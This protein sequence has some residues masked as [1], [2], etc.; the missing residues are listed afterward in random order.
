[1]K[2]LANVL[3]GA[4]LIL[5]GLHQLGGVS[6]P[7]SSIILAVLAAVTG[8]VFFFADSSEKISKQLGSILLGVYLVMI[9]AMSLFHISFPGSYVILAAIAVAA[10]VV[11]ALTRR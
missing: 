4:Y 5:T 8:I 6:F 9:G 11:V 7:K 2:T 3:L 10:G 1:M